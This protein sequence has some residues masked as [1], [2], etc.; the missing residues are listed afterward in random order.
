MSV[1]CP[2]NH[3]QQGSSIWST[4]THDFSVSGESVLL[5]RT[6]PTIG[7]C[8]YYRVPQMQ[9][10]DCYIWQVQWTQLVAVP[11]M[12]TL[13][14]VSSITPRPIHQIFWLWFHHIDSI[15]LNFMGF[16]IFFIFLF[17][18]FEIWTLILC[19][20]NLFYHGP[21][22]ALRRHSDRTF[23]LSF[24]DMRVGRWRYPQITIKICTLHGGSESNNIPDW[25]RSEFWITSFRVEGASTSIHRV[26]DQF[27]SLPKHPVDHC[28]IV[29]SEQA[30]WENWSVSLKLLGIMTVMLKNNVTSLSGRGYNTT[31]IGIWPW[32]T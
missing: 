2:Y 11:P 14:F 16:F 15:L 18:I 25:P 24:L 5:Q 29:Y 27:E 1:K 10:W 17:F 31:L 8:W 21:I 28:W 20:S 19:L 3:L 30:Y 13:T 32:V 6:C 12:I 26:N 23:R 9:Y 7:S 4:F 22:K